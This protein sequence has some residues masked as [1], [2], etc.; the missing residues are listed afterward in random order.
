MKSEA[1]KYIDAIDSA[2]RGTFRVIV[3]NGIVA[4]TS[5][6]I[7]FDATNEEVS[8]AVQKCLDLMDLYSGRSLERELKDD[9]ET[10]ADTER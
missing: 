3:Q 2:Y 10:T 5:D 4:V 9:T 7:R 8:R 1:E 6:P